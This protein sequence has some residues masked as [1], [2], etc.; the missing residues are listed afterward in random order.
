MS[1]EKNYTKM[2]IGNGKVDAKF[3]NNLDVSIDLDEAE[4]YAFTFEKNAKRYLKFKV[5]LLKEPDQ[6]ANTHTVYVL[7]MSKAEQTPKKKSR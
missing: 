4:K 2:F 5:A 6:F 3:E 1:T 7:Q